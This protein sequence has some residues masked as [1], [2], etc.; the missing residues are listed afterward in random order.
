MH[1]IVYSGVSQHMDER[2]GK[3]SDSSSQGVKAI[4]Q[5]FHLKSADN[6][7][8]HIATS[9]IGSGQMSGERPNTI[10]IDGKDLPAAIHCK[11]LKFK[12]YF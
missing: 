8:G 5:W 1:S 4:H 2:K 9:L 12:G 7:L 11:E 6:D 3:R 10:Y